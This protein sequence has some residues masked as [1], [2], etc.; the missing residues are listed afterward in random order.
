[1]TV[2]GTAYAVQ[3][4]HDRKLERSRWLGGR[5]VTVAHG[6]QHTTDQLAGEDRRCCGKSSSGHEA[7]SAL[8]REPLRRVHECVFA[9]LALESEPIDPRL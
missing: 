6:L 2:A 4:N 3:G 5:K 9:V 1:M 8:S 7:L